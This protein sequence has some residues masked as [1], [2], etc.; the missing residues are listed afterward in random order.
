M[1]PIPSLHHELVTVSFFPT[2]LVCSWIQKIATAP[3]LQS[4]G[5]VGSFNL[6][7]YKRYQLGNLE[8]LNLI[9]YNPTIIKKYIS[10]FL[11]EHNL[12]NAFITFSLDGPAVIEKFIAMPTSTPARTDFGFTTAGNI[13]WEYRYVYQNDDGQYIFYVYA[14]PRSL[15]LQYQL[16]AI[17]G[18]CNLITIT[19][20]T[21]VLLET[22]KNIFGVAF[23]K[24]Q[25][26]VDMMRHNNNVEN[27]ISLDALRRMIMISPGVMLQDERIYIATACGLFCAE[28][29]VL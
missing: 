10:S 24:S 28:L 7:A 15:L 9:P 27:L 25:L 5:A 20:K 11:R 22:Y 3:A 4:L 26:A 16:L 23:R 29:P 8:L 18:Q 2:A 14:V 6:R 12:Q 13:G 17:A 19:T 21:A 1:W